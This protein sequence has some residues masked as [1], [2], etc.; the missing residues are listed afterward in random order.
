MHGNICAFSYGVPHLFGALNVDKIEGA[1]VSMG[2][3]EN[4]RIGDW[5]EFLQGL[6]GLMQVDRLDLA[7]KQ[8]IASQ[9]AYL[10][11]DRMI[12]ALIA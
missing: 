12:K 2:I 8:T 4:H 11:S 9:R 7:K 6:E 5:S 10:A 1:M 3:D